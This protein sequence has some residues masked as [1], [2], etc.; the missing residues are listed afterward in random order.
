MPPVPKSKRTPK[1]QGTK[2]QVTKT[3]PTKAQATETQVTSVQVTKKSQGKVTKQTVESITCQQ[4]GVSGLQLQ[5]IK[6]ELCWFKTMK[7][8]IVI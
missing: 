1:P 6:T 7:Y 2:T 8:I 5:V 3:W 4:M